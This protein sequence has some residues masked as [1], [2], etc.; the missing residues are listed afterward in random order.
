MRPGWVV[1]MAPVLR[2]VWGEPPVQRAIWLQGETDRTV[3]HALVLALRRCRYIRAILL[4]LQL[5]LNADVPEEAL[6]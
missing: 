4:E 3:D 2:M 5:H 6:H 1:D